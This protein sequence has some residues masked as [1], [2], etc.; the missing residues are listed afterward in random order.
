MSEVKRNALGNRMPYLGRVI[1]ELLELNEDDQL[2]KLCTPELLPIIE[3]LYNVVGN[4]I[5]HEHSMGLAFK[6]MGR[7]T[8]TSKQR[9]NNLLNLHRV[10]N[11]VMNGE[12]PQ[13]KEKLCSVKELAMVLII[14]GI[15]ITK[16]G[17][18]RKSGF[19]YADAIGVSANSLYN[20]WNELDKDTISQN[21]F[22]S[23]AE[24]LIK[25]GILEKLRN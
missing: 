13:K 15:A 22:R 6:S 21:A 4:D 12:R 9:F 1:Q 5:A 3:K 7:E 10:I 2:R 14:E 23:K 18:D 11:D 19:N 16:K 25:N 24:E 8:E 17:I 20:T